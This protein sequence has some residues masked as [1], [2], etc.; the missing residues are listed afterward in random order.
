MP[1]SAA[2]LTN[3]ALAYRQINRN[4]AALSDFDRA[5]TADPSHAPAYLGRANLLRAQGNLDQAK[6]DLDQAIQLNPES[7]Q[8]F[9]ARGLIWQREGNNAQAIT[10]FDN[11]IDRDPFARAPYLARGQSLIATGKS[12][13][14][15]EDFNA[16]LN[17]DNKNADAW[18]G[19]G[20]AYEKMRQ[21]RPRRPRTTGARC[22]SIPP[23]PSPRM[24]RRASAARNEARGE[25]GSVSFLAHRL[26][27][28]ARVRRGAD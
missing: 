9:H 14:A 16:A 2:A 13:R 15:V 25:A 18:A 19:L 24:A 26:E 10:D 3:R 5:I 20:L 8:A 7:A 1:N 11:A 22:R 23:I 17:V 12:D 28:C 4:D 21:A 27:G 6:A